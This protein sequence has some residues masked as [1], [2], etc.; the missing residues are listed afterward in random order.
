MQAVSSGHFELVRLLLDHKNIE[1]NHEVE[2]E[3]ALSY[4]FQHSDSG[5]VI[6]LGHKQ[7]EMAVLL[8]VHGA[9]RPTVTTRAYANYYDWATAAGEVAVHWFEKWRAPLIKLI[10]DQ[11]TIC[12]GRELPDGVVDRIMG[13]AAP[14]MLEIF[15]TMRQET[16]WKTLIRPAM[17]M[18]STDANDLT[19]WLEGRLN[20]RKKT[21][22]RTDDNA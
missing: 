2:G 8:S 13:F 7:Y 9:A 18:I 10:R 19:N 3:N 22:G 1:V 4:V 21:Q 14:S 12:K 17:P 16:W 20:L 6:V 15:E 11:F 5:Y